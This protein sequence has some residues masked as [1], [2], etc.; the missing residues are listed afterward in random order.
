M[1]TLLEIPLDRCS[2]LALPPY[3]SNTS[4]EAP[5]KQS[6]AAALRQAKN[7]LDLD[8]SCYGTPECDQMRRR[9]FR[10]HLGIN[11]TLARLYV[12]TADRQSYVAANQ[13][14]LGASAML[15]LGNTGLYADSSDDQIVSY[16]RAKA[17]SFERD[18]TEVARR[19]SVAAAVDWA[20]LQAKRADLKFPLSPRH[21][22][23][24]AKELPAIAR[25]CDERWW[26]RQLRTK[27]IQTLEHFLRSQGLV[28]AGKSS[29]ISARG[30][31]HA[32]SRRRANRRALE[33]MEA[34]SNEG[35]VI[36]LTDAVDASV[37]NPEVRRH[38]LMT[39]T[40]GCEAV[41]SELGLLGAF[42]TIT[43]PSKYHP[44]RH[45]R[46]RNPKY[47]QSSPLDA[48][49]HLCRVWA[50]ARAAWQRAGIQTFGM[51]VVEPHHDG[52]PHWHLL[53]FFQPEDLPV[54]W[55]ILR[56]K[57][58]AEDGNE[59]G[60]QEKRATLVVIDP[61]KGSA[62]GYIAKYIAKNIDGFGVGEDFEGCIPGAEGAE[63]ATAWARLWGI[64]QFQPIGNTS[65]T[66]WR[67]LR[68]LR[69]PIEGGEENPLEPIRAACDAG[70]WG[71]YMK[72]TGGAF[73]RRS[74]QV[75]RLLKAD[76]PGESLYGEIVKRVLGV[77]LGDAPK[78]RPHIAVTRDKVWSV[79]RA[80]RPQA[81][82]PPP[83][84]PLDLCQ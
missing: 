54:A 8:L 1:A 34:V 51:R 31:E 22:G 40:R 4:S 62:A 59:R 72:L 52:T 53:L 55:G 2:D 29:A 63:R 69:S 82:G 77:V 60:A 47:N 28:C 36:N 79:R 5:R 58:L 50:S 7:A 78:G 66:V 24:K 65:V 35:D 20:E 19:F 57:A 30:L 84:G 42:L 45:G 18:F 23:N 25:M 41:A 37:S 38:E 80:E 56:E 67:E 61:A 26:R 49:A 32:R 12:E 3:D 17:R 83:G 43:C 48:Q 9:I 75:V 13:A 76:K 64:R 68:R 21:R 74:E 81:T 39:R 71:L 15:K 14:L 6:A 33:R 44:I 70:D 46:G 11:L 27:A 10:R 73:V 16:S